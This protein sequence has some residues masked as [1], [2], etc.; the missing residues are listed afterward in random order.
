MLNIPICLLKSTPMKP[1]APPDPAASPARRRLLDTATRLF[2]AEGIRAVG[3]DRIIAEAGVAKATF[4]KHFPSKDDLVLAYVEEQDRLG[5]DAVAALPKQPPREMIA[6]IM[7]R[8]SEAA[9]AG[10]YRGC[11]FLNAGAEYPVPASPVRQAIDARRAW[12]HGVLRDLLAADGDPAPALTASLLVAL[13]D[14]LL[15]IAYL[16]GPEGVPSL[17]REALARLLVRH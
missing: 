1:P 4:Y 17:V 11:P 5:R 7:G 12:Y 3:I 15:E 2:Y 16:D 13:S 10:D 8:I 14:G 9:V 6:A